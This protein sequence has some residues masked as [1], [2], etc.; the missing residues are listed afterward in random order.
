GGIW[1]SADPLP[2]AVPP[3]AAPEGHTVRWDRRSGLPNPDGDLVTAPEGAPADPADPRG[4]D[5]RGADPRGATGSGMAADAQIPLVA[6]EAAAGESTQYWTRAR[7][8]PIDDLPPPPDEGRAH[9]RLWAAGAGTAVVVVAIVVALLLTR[10][11]ARPHITTNT[12]TPPVSPQPNLYAPVSL[13]V[14]NEVGPTVTLRWKDPSNGK[15]PFVVAVVGSKGAA[16]TNS[17]TQT[18]IAGLDATK[19]YCFVVGAY[20]AVGSPPAY[21]APVCVRGGTAT[22]TTQATGV[23]TST[24]APTGHAAGL[25]PQWELATPASMGAITW[26][27]RTPR[28]LMVRASDV[29]G[30]RVDAAVGVGLPGH[31]P[32]LCGEV[33]DGEAVGCD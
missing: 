1:P 24:T 21:A 15:Y 18:V 25:R 6:P 20:Y 4:A 12:V 10:S 3:A 31:G 29:V 33:G 27:R 28:A 8:T 17:E 14:Y 22:S 11:P 26:S 9:T 19:G 2:T 23:S 7:R 5:P 16:E 13:T 32:D 30:G